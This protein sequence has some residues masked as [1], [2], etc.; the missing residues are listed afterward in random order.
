MVSFLLGTE[1]LLQWKISQSPETDLDSEFPVK[2]RYLPV[3]RWTIRTALSVVFT[4][5]PPAPLALLVS[6]LK[7]LGLIT[8]L[9]Y[10]HKEKLQF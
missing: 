7:S 8:S 5:C 4:C 1:D 9:I 10:T 3:G 2:T 6:I